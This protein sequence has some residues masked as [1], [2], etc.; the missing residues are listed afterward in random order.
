LELREIRAECALREIILAIVV[1]KVSALREIVLAIVIIEVITFTELEWLWDVIISIIIEIIVVVHLI[2]THIRKHIPSI[3]RLH[4]IELQVI[5]HSFLLLLVVT[6]IIEII[7]I[8]ID[9]Y[10]V[11][12]IIYFNFVI[13]AFSF[14]FPRQ[15]IIFAEIEGLFFVIRRRDQIDDRFFSSSGK[16]IGVDSE[17]LVIPYVDRRY[18]IREII[19]LFL[20]FGLD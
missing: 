7:V 19:R 14:V 5:R 6:I 12:I 4:L 10:V 20:D 13:F 18:Q 8:I 16:V 15:E 1:I 2:S 3:I 11:R 17:M 9:T